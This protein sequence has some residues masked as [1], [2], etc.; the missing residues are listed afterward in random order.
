MNEISGDNVPD[1]SP[2]PVTWLGFDAGMPP[3]PGHVLPVPVLEPPNP[4]PRKSKPRI[5]LILAA[6]LVLNSFLGAWLLTKVGSHHTTQPSTSASGQVE[7]DTTPSAIARVVD[8]AIVDINTY[9]HV[10]GAPAGS[11][12]P[13]GA[14]TGMILTSAGQ[15]LTNNHVVEGAVKIEVTIAGRSG[16]STATVVGVDPSQDVALIQ[17]QGVSGLPTITPADAA[18]V[19]VGNHVLGIGNALGRGGAPSVVAGSISGLDRTITAGNPGGSSEQL[20]GMLQTDAQIQPGDSGGALVDTSAHV[21]GMITAGG[22]HDRNNPGIITGYAIPLDTALGIVNQIRAGQ[23]NSTILLGDRGHMG[24]A[25]RP[26]D[27]QVARQLHV[28]SGALVVGVEPGGPA[29]VAGMTAPSVIESIGGQTVI[30]EVALGPILHA[31][32]PGAQVEVTWVD[33]HGTHTKTVTLNVGP[34]V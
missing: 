25:V 2:Q 19:S 12:Q 23:S 29:D 8:P 27:A 15:I 17:V 13:L 30:S 24:V 3:P 14:G 18:S 9:A 22:T 26:L 10:L 4:T 33:A 16:T 21:I 32:I 11:M 20:T 1:P 28:T 7:G 5:S 34:A 6:F 31:Y